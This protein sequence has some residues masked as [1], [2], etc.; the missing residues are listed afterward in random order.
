MHEGQG[1]SAWAKEN[2][3]PIFL[4]KYCINFLRRGGEKQKAPYRGEGGRVG[5]KIDSHEKGSMGSLASKRV[6]SFFPQNVPERILHEVKLY[7]NSQKMTFLMR[8][9]SS[10]RGGTEPPRDSFLVA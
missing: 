10:Q 7:R 8:K 4:L 5:Q 3:K 6:A 2:Q 9:F 1:A